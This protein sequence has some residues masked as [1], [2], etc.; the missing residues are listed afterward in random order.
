M[1]LLALAGWTIVVTGCL[2]SNV[3][4]F[5]GKTLCLIKN[6]TGYPC[7]SCGVG[8]GILNLTKFDIRG[9]IMQNPLSLI[10][11]VGGLI[12][13]IWEIRDVLRKDASLFRYNVRTGIWLKKNPV[14]III[15][16]AL[17]L[18]NWI[19]NLHKF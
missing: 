12:I 9:A 4:W 19:W 17:I 7:P 16:A 15:F 11:A 8:R 14:V 10:V 18:I 6:I 3:N 2:L 1:S 5:E 13:P